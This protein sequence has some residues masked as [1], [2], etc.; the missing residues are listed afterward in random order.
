MSSNCCESQSPVCW[1]VLKWA[2][3]FILTYSEVSVLTKSEASCGSGESYLIS[4][5]RVLGLMLIFRLSATCSRIFSRD[6]GF[7]LP[8]IPRALRRGEKVPVPCSGYIL[9]SRFILVA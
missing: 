9:F 4:T 6:G 8:D 7:V 3:T 1:L 5:S 2:S